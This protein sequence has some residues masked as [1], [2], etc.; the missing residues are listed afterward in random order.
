MNVKIR[1]VLFVRT[2]RRLSYF[3]FYVYTYNQR[4]QKCLV[5]TFT[6][7]VCTT[8]LLAC[9]QMNKEHRTRVYI[10]VRFVCAH[11]C[12]SYSQL[13]VF[14]TVLLL[15]TKRSE[16]SISFKLFLYHVHST[17]VEL[18]INLPYP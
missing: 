4:K 9:V 5:A 10:L 14:C 13:S 16:A 3:T 8:Q 18:A 11:T 2:I 17:C 1:N 7:C 15:T 6:T 12:Y